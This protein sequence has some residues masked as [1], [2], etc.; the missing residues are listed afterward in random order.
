MSWAKKARVF[1][2]FGALKKYH[3]YKLYLSGSQLLR[4]GPVESILLSS[5]LMLL[6]NKL[7]LSRLFKTV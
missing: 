2:P 3:F 7:E 4:Q 6:T 5:L 1:V